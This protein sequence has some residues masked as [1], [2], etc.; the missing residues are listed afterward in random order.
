[1]DLPFSD[2]DVTN[3]FPGWNLQTPAIGKGGFKVAYRA[4][5]GNQP[6]VVKI[7]LEPFNGDPDDFDVTEF[8]ERLSRELNAMSSTNC[9]H[10]VKITSDAEVAKI[11]DQR[12]VWYAEPYYPGGTLAERLKSGPLAL[13]EVI[14]LAKALFVAVAAMW[15]EHRI[16]HRDIKPGNIVFDESGLPVLL[17]L[18]IALYG[19]LTNI[20]NSFEQSPMTARYAAPEQ[21]ELRKDAQID[22]RTDHFLI[23]IVVYE[24]L[25][26]KHPFWSPGVGMA[27]Y[28]DRMRSFGAPKFA[29]V[30]CPTN[31]Q[32]VLIR[33]L[34]EKVNRRYR[35]PE[36]PLED[37]DN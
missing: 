27:A 11:G 21:F 32:K 30:D 5:R 12:F 19:N 22:F 31:L 36:D 28:L 25:T 18:G 13:N 15:D 9:P 8:S 23:G 29:S 3:S 24:A 37:L 1:M 4:D 2:S 7:L 33:L 26:G 17:D 14:D 10:I 34:S 20:T 35:R 6:E 16:V